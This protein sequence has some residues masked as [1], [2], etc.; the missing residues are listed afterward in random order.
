MTPTPA[1]PDAHTL[2][3][4]AAAML[5]SAPEHIACISA[6]LANGAGVAGADLPAGQSVP[7]VLAITMLVLAAF[8]AGLLPLPAGKGGFARPATGIVAHSWP[9]PTITPPPR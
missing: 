2:T 9:P 4:S 5:A 1:Q 7:L 6:L 3:Q 8:A